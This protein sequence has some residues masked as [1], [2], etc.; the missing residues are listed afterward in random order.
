MIG[1]R[2]SLPIL[3]AALI[4]AGL[5]LAA[6]VAVYG[7][8]PLLRSPLGQHALGWLLEPDAPPGLT[9]IAPG[10]PVPAFALPALQGALPQLPVPG[11]VTLIN[12]WASWCEPCREEF[13]LLDAFAREQEANIVQVTGIALDERTDA[14]RFLQQ[15]SASFPML[16]E[17]PGLHDSSA[18][19]G[20]TQGVL[21]YSVLI[22]ADGKLIARRFGAFKSMQDLRQWATQKL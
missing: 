10:E 8:G 20:N 19:L 16:L 4:A 14:L 17:S 11:Q 1:W 2:Q 6:S 5:G 13:P 12:Y 18:R 7:P 15:Q 22:G 9:V 21:P 3:A